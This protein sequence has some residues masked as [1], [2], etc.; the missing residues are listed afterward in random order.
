MP[1]LL[2][3]GGGSHS[4]CVF[5]SGTAAGVWTNNACFQLPLLVTIAV[6][7]HA[8]ARGIR[9]LRNSPQ[10]VSY[11]YIQPLPPMHHCTLLPYHCPLL[12]IAS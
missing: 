5:N 8:F 7:V 1:L 4:Y 10:S 11:R 12:R 3:V 2:R 9:A 6:N